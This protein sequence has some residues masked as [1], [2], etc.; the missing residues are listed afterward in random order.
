MS[1]RWSRQQLQQYLLSWSAVQRYIAENG[2]NPLDLIATDLQAS[3][4]DERVRKV[5]WPLTVIVRRK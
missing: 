2:S 4:G 1:L 5:V 3:W